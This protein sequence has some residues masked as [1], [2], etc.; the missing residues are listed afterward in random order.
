MIKDS[1]DEQCHVCVD[2]AGRFRYPFQ[3]EAGIAAAIDHLRVRCCQRKSPKRDGGGPER[4]G[5]LSAAGHTPRAKLS[6]AATRPSSSSLSLSGLLRFGRQRV[7]FGYDRF[8]LSRSCSESGCLI[9]RG[10]REPDSATG[11]AIGSKL[12]KIAIARRDARQP[13][14]PRA[15]RTCRLHRVVITDRSHQ[16]SECQHGNLE[17]FL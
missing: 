7:V 1:P 13:Q 12:G 16:V 4:L 17:T 6:C 5:P 14:L 8:R 15:D 10:F 3:A 2:T 11:A 9:F